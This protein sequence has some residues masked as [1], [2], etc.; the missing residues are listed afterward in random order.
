MSIKVLVVQ[1]QRLSSDSKYNRLELK[2]PNPYTERPSGGRELS[3]PVVSTKEAISKSERKD[4][5][6]EE[7]SNSPAAFLSP[8]ATAGALNCVI[9]TL[10][11]NR[12]GIS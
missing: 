2:F 4:W 7:S 8:E 1:D 5:Y 3:T 12:R 9:T 11:E 10:L 6:R